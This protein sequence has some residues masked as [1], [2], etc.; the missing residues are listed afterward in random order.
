[1]FYRAFSPHQSVKNYS[2]YQ[3]LLVHIHMI[4][5]PTT[6]PHGL[7]NTIKTKILHGKLLKR[8]EGITLEVPKNVSKIVLLQ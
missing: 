1:M 7:V 4:L 8:F 6:R 5:I 2:K 3:Y